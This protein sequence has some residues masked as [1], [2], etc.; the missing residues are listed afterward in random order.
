V[1]EVDKSPLNPRVKEKVI[2]VFMGAE[3][4]Q[5]HEFAAALERKE[6]QQTKAIGLLISLA[7]VSVL[8]VLVLVLL[9]IESNTRSP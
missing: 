2:P 1:S 7:G 8:V 4:V 9:G 6:A 5:I 3:L